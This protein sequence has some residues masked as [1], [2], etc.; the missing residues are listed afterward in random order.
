M[1]PVFWKA[2]E[3]LM[4]PVF[5]KAA[6][7]G[8]IVSL[9]ELVAAKPNTI[10]STTKAEKNTALH[11]AASEGHTLFVHHFLLLAGTNMELMV[12]Q[13]NDDDMPLHLAVRAGHLEV[14]E[15]LIL[16]L[17]WARGIDANLKEPT[18]MLNGKGNTPMHDALSHRQLDI[19]LKLL[20]VNPR[21]ANALNAEMQSPLYIAAREGYLHVVK[22]IAD[23]LSAASVST[24]GT[25][26][27]AL[28]QAVLAD[29][30]GALDILLDNIVKLVQVTDSSGNNALHYA[31]WHN[32]VHM[33]SMLHNKNST[34]AYM[35]NIEQQT[36]LHVAAKYGSLEAA[37]ELMKQCP[38]TVEMVDSCGRNA[39]HISII[40]NK[41]RVLKLLL[42][43]ELPEEILNKQDNDGNT[44]LH[45]A[46]KLHQG[47]SILWSLLNDLRINSY[48]INNEGH[49]PWDD[50]ILIEPMTRDLSDAIDK[51]DMLSLVNF[52]AYYPEMV[53]SVTPIRGHTSLHLAASKG[54]DWLVHHVLLYT[55]R[56][57]GF[58]TSKNSDGDTPLHLAVRAGHLEVVHHLMRYL[59]WAR[60][61]EPNLKLKE[62]L[63][64]PGK[65]GNTLLH[66]AVIHGRHLVAG[67][68]LN[69]CK[70]IKFTAAGEFI[71]EY[72]ECADFS[73]IYDVFLIIRNDDGDTALHLAVKAGNSVFVDMLIKCAKVMNLELTTRYAEGPITI[74]NKL[75]NTP[76]HD[77][78]L[79]RKS[80]VALKLL[81]ANPSC[82]HMLNAAMQSPFYIAVRDSLTYVVKKIA[83]QGLYVALMST[84]S[85]VL[86]QS[87]LGNNIRALEILLDR[88]EEL[89]ELTDLSGNN[90]LHYAAQHNNARI[91][92]ILLNKYSN[93]YKQNDEK[94]TPL[95]TAAYYGS[96]EAAKE[97]LK[98]F[99]DAIEMVDNTRQNALHIA[100]RNDKVDVL[101]LL[102]KYVLPEEIVN[103]QDRDG[104]TPLH[105]AAKLLHR[106]S[107]M[108]LLNDRRVKPWLLNQDE[109]TAFALSCKAGIFEMNADEM[110]LWKELKKHGSRRRSQQV[111]TEQQFR[112]LWYWGRRTYMVSS[113][114]INL[115][116][117]AM[118]SMATF[119]VT[120]AVPGGYSQQSGT[121]IVG[122]HLAFKIFA[123]GNTISMCGSTS[124]VLVLCYLSWQYH[125]QVLTRL[126]WA[127][128]LIVLS[129][130][131]AIISM[132][133]AVY[134]TIAPVSRF[135]AYAVIAVGASAPFLACLILRKSLTRK[136]LFT[137]WIGMKLVPQGETGHR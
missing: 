110:D 13:N 86:H 108:L 121:A 101:E 120:L 3:N 95:H 18:T 103:Q 61:I 33:I 119:A 57:V 14:V 114:V 53:Y 76:L 116:V 37:R 26:M 125:G 56:N 47:P 4:D 99:P 65:E 23:Q 74:A 82:A 19:A 132:L 5:R 27:T 54:D 128:M 16:Y 31:A 15:H 72:P 62:P 85:T 136:S 90:A 111:L 124:T 109:D 89:V 73:S 75:G 8:N 79:Q 59:A 49:T 80:D 29:D 118:M 38:N 100:A 20:E 45:H 92:S 9:Q 107:T 112:P 130:L 67:S 84:H 137:R 17:T 39:F 40:N 127:N 66:E 126:I 131:T 91:V 104:N 98:Q 25:R 63:I 123:V 51:G 97:L 58:I 77:A 88:Y 7:K 69:S 60:E 135:L 46:A 133:T 55:N 134:L 93:P 52:L 78:V 117:A 68:L 70:E 22:K 28:H 106:Q 11:I 34:L 102:L 105:H 12:S 48:M 1:D 35:K 83:D 129:V 36:A 43:Y 87:V 32:R 122:H 2:A 41:L 10:Y 81:E 44:P 50:Q 21:C 94:H 42:E 71:K 24:I 96:A 64:T 30:I 113:V 6:D 115:F